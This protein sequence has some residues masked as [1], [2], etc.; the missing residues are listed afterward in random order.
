MKCF[1]PQG[2]DIGVS[3]CS[4]GGDR[5]SGFGKALIAVANPT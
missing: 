4:D 5:A 1:I 3:I 2:V